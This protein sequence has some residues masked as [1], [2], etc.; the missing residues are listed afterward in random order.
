MF[1]NL[2]IK[3]IHKSQHVQRNW[4]LSKSIA[5]E[6]LAVIENAVI[7]APS[8]Q[9]VTFLKP[10]F[11]TDRK[12]IERIH[13]ATTGFYIADGKNG[14]QAPG[15]GRMTTNPQ[16]LANLLI[17][18]ADGFNPEDAKVHTDQY[19]NA[20][21]MEK[22]KQQALGVAAGYVNVVSALLGYSSGCCSCCNK[23]EIQ[24]ILG[25]D[26]KPMLLMGVGIPDPTKA[27]REH[28]NEAHLTFPTHRK[29]IQVTYLD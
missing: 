1:N 10:Y 29:D 19:C 5:A 20:E 4:D 2:L 16:T 9:N 26:E 7:G 25:I 8:K 21:Q 15:K 23:D 24:K 28:H 22:D 3:A 12:K 14:G 13:R 17:V 11:I 6:D 27:R 18:F